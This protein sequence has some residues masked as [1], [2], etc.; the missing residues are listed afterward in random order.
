MIAFLIS[1]QRY[2]WVEVLSYLPT[3][4]RF[5]TATTVRA[6][7]LKRQWAGSER[8]SDVKIFP[9]NSQKSD[10][11]SLNPVKHGYSV[12]QEDARFQLPQ[13]WSSQWYHEECVITR[14]FQMRKLRLKAIE[15][16]AQGHPE[17]VIELVP[18]VKSPTPEP[19]TQP[20][21]HI[22]FPL[23]LVAFIPPSLS[24]VSSPPRASEMGQGA[25][26]YKTAP[27]CQHQSQV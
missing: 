20:P 22:T 5:P 24:T 23:L 3:G 11:F 2:S 12:S 25:Q 4:W 6:K 15:S 16:I 27:Y 10:Q 19:H 8:V 1:D 26:P 13:R 7:M 17:F 21:C 14:I 18:K 9:K